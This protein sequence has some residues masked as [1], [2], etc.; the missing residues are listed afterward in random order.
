MPSSRATP[1]VQPAVRKPRRNSAPPS[2]DVQGAVVTFRDT[3]ADRAAEQQLLAREREYRELFNGHPNAMWI[4]DPRTLAVVEVNDAAIQQYGYTRDEYLQ[5]TLAQLCSDPAAAGDIFG[6]S[7]QCNTAGAACVVAHRRKDGSTLH[8][9]VFC[10]P[11]DFGG[12][13]RRLATSIDVTE[14]ERLHAL[15]RQAQ[16]SL[17]IAQHVAQIGSW[18]YDLD[19][20]AADDYPLQW[21][22]ETFRIFGYQ[23]GA[24]QPSKTHFY[25]AVPPPDRPA[26]ENAVE[27]MLSTGA[28]LS[29]EHRIIRP[30]GTVRV[31]AEQAELLRDPQTGRGTRVVGTVRDVTARW[32]AEQSLRRSE[33]LFRQLADAM[34]QI[35]FAAG[36][37][38]ALDYLNQRALDYIG[39][40]EDQ[41]RGWDW[42]SVIHPA[43]VAQLVQQWAHS[44]ATGDPLEID[45]RLRHS[46]DGTYHWHLC[47]CVAVRDEN[48]VIVRWFGTCTDVDGQL[49]VQSQLTE[50][51]R[52]ACMGSW[53]FDLQTN[54]GTWSDELYRLL[55]FEVG[56]PVSFTTFVRCV[57][58]D[59]RA[60]FVAAADTCRKTGMPF[61]STHRVVR[62][63]GVVR[64]FQQRV[65][66]DCDSAGQPVRLFGTAQDVTEQKSAEEMLRQQAQLLDLAHDAIIVRDYVDHRITFWNAAAER[67][68][69]WTA[70]EAIGQ[71]IGELVYEDAETFQRILESLANTGEFRGEVNLITKDRRAVVVNVRSTV[72]RD[73]DGMPQSVLS[74]NTDITDRKKLEQQFLRAQRLES[75]GTLAAGVAHDLN[76]ILVP[77][78]M[79]APLLREEQ[80]LEDREN[81]LSLVEASAERGASIIKQV[82][83]FARG[84]DGE[85]LLMQPAYLIKD[86]AKIIQETFPKSIIVRANYNDNLRTICADLT[87]LHQVLLNLCVNA[88]DAMPDGGNLNISAENFDV[89]E[90][91]AAMTP[92]A[93]AGPHVVLQV[94]DTGTGIPRAV[95]SKIFD[96]FFTTKEVGKGTGLGLSTVV[97]IVRSHGGFVN[98]YS[99]VNHGTTFKVFLPASDSGDTEPA[100]AKAAIPRGNGETV[101][102]VD[103]E[104]SI[105][106]VGSA[107]LTHHGYNVVT[108]EDGPTALAR[109]A[110]QKDAIDIVVTDMVMP[111]M[112]GTVLIRAL[113]K[114]R[115]DL[116]VIAT[117]GRGEEYD[118][119]ELEALKVGSCIAKPYSQEVLLTALHEVL[120]ATRTIA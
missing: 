66:I 12:E 18:E 33:R 86:V 40:Q 79:A 112:H 116:P 108:A 42:R 6:E 84:V 41:L 73:A 44:I 28:R 76:N 15:A 50:A 9:E 64:T 31:V 70:A 92:G 38:G 39:A 105:R 94:T 75:I 91:F 8:A 117:T 85:R 93:T 30:D 24:F 81:L 23:P 106:D 4:Y 114:M 107:L 71:R 2:E 87:Q 69:G 65:E 14:R 82:L 90:H 104:P 61:E 96:P 46:P 3:T 35:V 62:Q 52:V 60:D 99:E 54:T 37:D 118:T 13:H 5:M 11:I 83:T 51:Q 102:L 68:Y 98:V 22:D 74:I 78:L 119:S 58:P 113:R 1:R 100:P 32:T 56:E 53:S 120:N 72:V 16:T 26:I 110:A 7:C 101:L 89:D 17:E 25:S 45:L 88:R 111:F 20:G 67:I 57:H 48:G 63:D 49:R 27:Q 95:L 115:T 34:P 21:S 59:D 109:F 29:L 103:D 47:R 19:S 97:G 80:S 43:D 10:S 55:G 36:P 77:I